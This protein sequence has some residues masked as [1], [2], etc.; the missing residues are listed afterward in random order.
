MKPITKRFL[1]LLRSEPNPNSAYQ[2]REDGHC[3]EHADSAHIRIEQ[4]SDRSGLNLYIDSFTKGESVYIPVC[5]TGGGTEE[6]VTNDFYI[7]SGAEVTIIAGCGMH[8]VEGETSAHHGIHRF[9]L[10]DHANVIYLEEHLGTGSAK[11]NRKMNPESILE[12]EKGAVLQMTSNQRGGVESALRWVRARLQ[13]ESLLIVRESILTERSQS[14]H[15]DFDILLEGT[16]C[17]ADLV[18]RAVARHRSRQQFHSRVCAS[19]KS[20]AHSAC[21]AILMG[22]GSVSAVPALTARHPEAVLIHEAAIGK[23][24]EEQIAKL[25]TLGLSRAKAEEVILEGFLQL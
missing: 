25:M 6:T 16:S 9:Y 17:R 8:C 14:V 11:A 5:I 2:I 18:S 3:I 19:A 10:G 24:A 23:I 7:D 20:S 1:S 13:E 21:D 12:L 4:K 15:S 22:S